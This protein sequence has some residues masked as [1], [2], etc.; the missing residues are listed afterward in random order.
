MLSLKYG[1]EKKVTSTKDIEEGD[2][3]AYFCEHQHKEI[4]AEV[5]GLLEPVID[6][7]IVCRRLDE[8]VADLVDFH[9]V[10]VY[11]A[12]KK[13]DFTTAVICECGAAHTSNPTFHLRF[14]PLF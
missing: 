5:L 4:L 10:G 2:I 9:H 13:N 7:I 12:K 1:E 8:E 11:L 3:I 6:N 14:C